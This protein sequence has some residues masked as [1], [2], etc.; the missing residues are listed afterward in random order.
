MIAATF[1]VLFSIGNVSAAGSAP[2]DVGDFPAPVVRCGVLYLPTQGLHATCIHTIE[3]KHCFSVRLSPPMT[4]CCTHFHTPFLSYPLLNRQLMVNLD[5]PP[6]ERWS[7]IGKQYAAKT[8]VTLQYLRKMVIIYLNSICYELLELSPPSRYFF[9]PLFTTP[10]ISPSQLI[11]DLPAFL[12]PFRFL[13]VPLFRSIRSFSLYVFNIL[14]PTPLPL[15]LLPLLFSHQAGKGTVLH[16]VVEALKD[17][18]IAGGGWSKD[19]LAELQ[20]EHRKHLMTYITEIIRGLSNPVQTNKHAQANSGKGC[21]L[22]S[23]SGFLSLF[24]PTYS[25]D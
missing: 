12:I 13:C 2:S 16:P 9:L 1:L 4:V 18:V 8:N 7:Y 6:K 24:P 21:S 11:K 19:Q 15:F 23:M 5:L 22:S 10:L 3:K 25:N 17:A 14:F 20:G